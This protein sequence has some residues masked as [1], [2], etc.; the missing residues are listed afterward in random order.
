MKKNKPHQKFTYVFPVP[1]TDAERKQ[2]TIDK[3]KKLLTLNTK[4][5]D[6]QLNFVKY[7]LLSISKIFWVLQFFCFVYLLLNSSTANGMDDIQILFLTIVPIMTF[8]I[9]PEILK[10]RIYHTNE[11]EAVCSYSP[12]KVIA[13]KMV[14]ISLSNI[15][16]ISVASLICGFYLQLN[17]G[18]L[19][20][21]GFIPFNISVALSMIVFNFFRI[22]SS[23]AMLSVSTILTVALIQL[24]YTSIL[25]TDA[26]FVVFIVSLLFVTLSVAITKARF[27]KIREVYYEAGY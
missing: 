7:Q 27:G 6:A 23:Y 5:T 21:R 9:L 13:T 19:L 3:A 10:S 11:T 2:A 12:E 18:E 24:R 14:L 26:W 15:S 25:L 1:K 20:C 4:Y 22:K 8:Y 16:V 17:I